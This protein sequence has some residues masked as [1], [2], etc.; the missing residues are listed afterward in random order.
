MYGSNRVLLAVVTLV[1]I[2]K[3]VL[4]DLSKPSVFIIS[5]VIVT[6]YNEYTSLSEGVD[7]FLIKVFFLVLVLSL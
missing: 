3:F 4:G 7:G 6:Q 5:L 2:H 1:S